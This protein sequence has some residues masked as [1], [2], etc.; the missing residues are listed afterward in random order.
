MAS[1]WFPWQRFMGINFVF[2]GMK[3]A[4]TTKSVKRTGKPSSRPSKYPV[5]C[6]VSPFAAFALSAFS[7]SGENEI[8]G[9]S[10]SHLGQPDRDCLIAQ[11]AVSYPHDYRST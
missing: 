5:R 6:N 8:D 11:I 10:N 4:E 1:R 2:I 3:E 7:G 9:E